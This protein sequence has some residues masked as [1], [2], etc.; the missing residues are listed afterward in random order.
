MANAPAQF[1]TRLMA[2][3]RETTSRVL[4]RKTL[5]NETS[6]SDGN[7]FVSMPGGSEVSRA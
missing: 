1:N 7:V 2:G 3:R 5:K 4:T 6:K